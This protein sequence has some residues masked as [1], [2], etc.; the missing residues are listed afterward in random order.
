M[1]L[2][3]NAN[4]LGTTGSTPPARPGFPEHYPQHFNIDVRLTQYKGQENNHGRFSQSYQAA[5]TNIILSQSYLTFI[6]PKSCIICRA[7][8]SPELQLQHCAQCQ[9]ALYCFKTCHRK[10]WETQ[11]KKIC[12]LFNVG[13]GDMRDTD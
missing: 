10:Y 13:H 11:H 6:M 3:R 12:K 5:C 1:H 2:C 7:A 4:L 8:E 9:S